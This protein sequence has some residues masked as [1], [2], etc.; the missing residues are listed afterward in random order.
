M[1]RSALEEHEKPGENLLIFFVP[2]RGGR[3]QPQPTTALRAVENVDCLSSASP[4]PASRPARKSMFAP[5][6]GVGQGEAHLLQPGQMHITC[7]GYTARRASRDLAMDGESENKVGRGYQDQ[8]REGGRRVPPSKTT[9]SQ[10]VARRKGLI[11]LPLTTDRVMRSPSA[12]SS[13]AVQTKDA[14]KE[15]EPT[16][17]GRLDKQMPLRTPGNLRE[18]GRASGARYGGQQGT[19]SR[20]RIGDSRDSP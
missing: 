2:P 4:T 6:G 7:H 19:G 1:I 16:S 5:F 9:V 18:P 14:R 13:T 17:Q 15:T 12:C 20:G 10:Q 3:Q 11:S 8:E